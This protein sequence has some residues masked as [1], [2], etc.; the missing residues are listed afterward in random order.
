[1]ISWDESG[2]GTPAVLVHGITEDRTT[3]HRVVPLLEDRFRCVRLDLRGHGRSADADDYSAL[4]MAEDVARVVSEANIDEPPLLVGH[5][6]GA[7]VVT[8]YATQAPAAGVVNVDQSLRLGDFA[9][10]LSPL[11]DDLRGDRFSETVSAVVASLGVDALPESDRAYVDERHLGARQ[12]VV[13]GVWSQVLESSP[14]E[15]TALAES[16]LSALGVPYLAIHGSDPGAGYAGWLRSHLPGAEVE[17]WNGHGH[18]PHL[19]D[20][21]RFARRV[22]EFADRLGG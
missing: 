14:E 22:R 15:L 16:L 3:W 1:M 12:D 20:P 5:S 17:V 6:L 21:E 8:A 13:M 11:A 4:A 2:S 19:V 7:V 10:G 18:Y 9:A